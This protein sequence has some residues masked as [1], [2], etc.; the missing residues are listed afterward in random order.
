MSG[1]GAK[2]EIKSSSEETLGVKVKLRIHLTFRTAITVQ[3]GKAD[4]FNA[5]NY[6]SENFSGD[7][8]AAELS[9]ADIEYNEPDDADYNVI[10]KLELVVSEDSA[11]VMEQ[12]SCR[13]DYFVNNWCNRSE[14]V[15]VLPRFYIPS[16]SMDSFSPKLFFYL[17]TPSFLLEKSKGKNLHK[18]QYKDAYVAFYNIQ[19]I[20]P[21][22]SY[23]VS[24]KEKVGSG[25][26]KSAM[27]ANH[28]KMFALMSYYS[29]LY[30]NLFERESWSWFNDNEKMWSEDTI[31]EAVVNFLTKKN[32]S[33]S[34]EENV[35]AETNTEENSSL[36]KRA[37]KAVGRGTRK[38]YNKVV[39]VASAV[40]G[41]MHKITN[42]FI[43]FLFE[44]DGHLINRIYIRM[45]DLLY[46]TTG[47][48]DDVALYTKCIRNILD[49][50]RNEEKV[51]IYEFFDLCGYWEYLNGHY[52][53]K[54]PDDNS[55][56][57]AIQMS[58]LMSYCQQWECS[59]IGKS[60][61]NDDDTSLLH[62]I[63]N[64]WI[65]FGN[66]LTGFGAVLYEN[67]QTQEYVYCFKGTDFDSLAKDWL[68]TNFVQGISGFSLQHYYAVMHAKILDSLIADKQ[69]WFTGHSL[70]GGLAS[71]ATIATK[72]R[73]GFTFNAAGLNIIGV[74][75]NQLLNSS[76]DSRNRVFP[77][78]I[79]DE[80]LDAFQHKV[81]DLLSKVKITLLERGFGNKPVE[82]NINT[83]VSGPGEKHGINNFLLKEVMDALDLYKLTEGEQ[84][85][86]TKVLLI[87]NT[88]D[89]KVEARI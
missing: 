51:T 32:K 25:V 60:N 86:N 21:N 47:G 1:P 77:Y 54:L 11:S 50:C 18:I 9:A 57:S 48:S 23:A 22:G 53:K 35:E 34:L 28:V 63:M 7:T 74:T 79:K 80:V 72:N 5:G 8:F 16:Y 3:S 45:L 4:A 67:K 13:I 81:S 37:A 71:A 89:A 27:N 2:K 64:K 33:V 6:G 43:D 31:T 55:T 46:I 58:S 84:E 85:G 10:D 38:I 39:K 68:M 19:N 87:Y 59:I 29:Y 65:D 15:E 73:I 26:L 42:A 14:V 44:Y 82:Y 40:V 56:T 66:W 78:R 75:I 76:A 52:L 62:K 61:N 20:Q 49:R 24:V 36:L 83:R 69:L 17:Y 70:G 41:V 30:L 12:V 88:K